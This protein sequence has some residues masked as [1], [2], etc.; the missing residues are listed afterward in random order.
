[1]ADK[2]EREAAKKEAEEQ[3]QQ[4][5]Q[6]EQTKEKGNSAAGHGEGAA[7]PAGDG[8]EAK[9]VG[10]MSPLPDR[11][12]PDDLVSMMS[13]EELH[14]LHQLQNQPSQGWILSVGSD[15]AP[16]LTSGFD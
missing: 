7:K 8:T 3:A 5:Q 1:M 12:L 6:A 10:S 13:K 4:A 16:T 9:G 14:Q 2:A 11:K 15:A